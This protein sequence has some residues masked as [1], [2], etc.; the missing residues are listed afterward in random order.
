MLKPLSM[1]AIR[2]A[3]RVGREGRSDV[4]ICPWSPGPVVRIAR[5]GP[6]TVS[7]PSQGLGT[8]I[9]QLTSLRPLQW[10]G[11]REVKVGHVLMK[12]TLGDHYTFANLFFAVAAHLV[13][14]CVA[15]VSS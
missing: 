12:G 6:E 9:T 11:A 14:W 2:R 4:C 3:L 15:E 7:L 1:E 10:P 13:A 8:D 5:L